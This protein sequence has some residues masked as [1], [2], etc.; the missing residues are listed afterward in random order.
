MSPKKVAKPADAAKTCDAGQLSKMIGL[1]KY[2][3]CK[4]DSNRHD[5][6]SEAL[7]VYQALNNTSDRQRFL[8]P[9]EQAGNGK[10]PGS[11]KFAVEFKQ[12]LVSEKTVTVGATE[13]WFTRLSLDT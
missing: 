6:A 13:D 4:P 2:H 9:F 11:L 7:K 10:T 1:L 12:S 5:E 3:S 8:E